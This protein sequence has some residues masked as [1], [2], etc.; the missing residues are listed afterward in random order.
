MSCENCGFKVEYD[1]NPKSLTIGV[2][3]SLDFN[4]RSML[5]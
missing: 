5:R 4:I 3:S 1:K 2:K